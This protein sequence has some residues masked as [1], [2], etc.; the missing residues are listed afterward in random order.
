M[1]DSAWRY[2]CLAIPFTRF[3]TAVFLLAGRHN[4]TAV[5]GEVVDMS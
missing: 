2:T 1:L 4:V 5:S 3:D